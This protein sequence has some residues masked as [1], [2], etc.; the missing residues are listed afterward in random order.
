MWRLITMNKIKIGIPAALLYYK[1]NILWTTFFE[2]LDCEVVI[3]PPT[4][5]KMLEIGTKKSS[6][7]SCLAMK[8]YMGHVDYLTDKCDYLFIP[9]I[10][11]LK[12]TE[13]TCTNF[14]ALY[15]LTK[16]TFDKKIINYNVDLEKGETEEKSFLKI[17][18]FL[19]Y[20]TLHTLNAY[21][22]A[23]ECQTEY[24]EKK[25]KNEMT[26]LN[27]TDKLK[28]LVAGHPYNIYDRLIGEQITNILKKNDIEILYS[29]IYKPLD[30]D[31]EIKPISK[32][33][34]WTYNKELIASICYHEPRVD[35]I[36][37]ISS[38]P[39]GPDSLSNEMIMRN[40]HIPITNI[41][42]DATDSDTGLITR[43]E[44]FIDIIEERKKN[45]ERK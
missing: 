22:H 20:N 9:R 21:H 44:S 4:D 10:K 34:Y 45:D 30:L 13:Q 16:T 11:C 33:N 15:D 7:E 27:E 6:D 42:L 24:D 40:V 41:I 18:K 1:Y 35:G 17:G 28:I 2:E 8:I 31:E 14:H 37:L 39:C 43:I 26:I 29:D 38:F 25:L 36:I 32:T 3:S 19:G 12:K 5:K 23:K